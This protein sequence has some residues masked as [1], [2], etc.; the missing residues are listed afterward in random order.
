MLTHEHS[1]AAP[2]SHTAHD[3][4]TPSIAQLAGQVYEA[5]PV[6]DRCRLLEHLMRPLG[7]LSLVAVAN[8]VFAKL[9]FRSGWHDLRIQPDDAQRVRV[10]DVIKLVDYVQQASV[11]VIDDLARLVAASPELACSAAAA[12]LVA[13]LVQRAARRKGGNGPAGESCAAPLIVSTGGK[14]PGVIG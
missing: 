5:A 14:T 1:A 4:A 9:W 8:G 12:T 10:G 11:E 3:G 6:S 7:A 13:V 2:Y